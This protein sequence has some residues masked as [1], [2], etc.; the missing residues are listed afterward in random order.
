[1][2]FFPSE[3]GFWLL[4]NSITWE[5]KNNYVHVTMEGILNKISQIKHSVECMVWP[6]C[7]LFQIQGSLKILIRCGKLQYFLV[8][9]SSF[10]TFSASTIQK[11][12]ERNPKIYDSKNHHR[13]IKS[14]WPGEKLRF[15]VNFCDLAIRMNEWIL[16]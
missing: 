1:M 4:T 6:W 10:K 16:I 12:N 3:E 2:L 11:Y 15:I 14:S 5:V 13:M 8:K 9:I 7:R